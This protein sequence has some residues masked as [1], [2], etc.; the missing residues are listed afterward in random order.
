MSTSSSFAFQILA[1][2]RR[3]KNLVVNTASGASEPLCPSWPSW[4]RGKS[5][6]MKSGAS[7]WGYRHVGLRFSCSEEP[8]SVGSLFKSLKTSFKSRS[9]SWVSFKMPAGCSHRT[10]RSSVMDSFL[11]Q[12]VAFC[13]R[14]SECRTLMRWE[15][16]T[17]FCL[18]SQVI[19]S[20]WM[21]VITSLSAHYW[22]IV[23]EEGMTEKP[24]HLM[25]GF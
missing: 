7:T 3:E 10:F 11:I 16:G 20:H 21:H 1:S 19:A 18:L 4:K 17:L 14:T 6:V 9:S 12:N 5:L 24:K 8:T 15:S 13:R 22:C 25:R 2:D 23:L